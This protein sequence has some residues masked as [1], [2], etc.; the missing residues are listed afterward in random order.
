VIFRTTVQ[1]YPEKVGDQ[2]KIYIARSS[3]LLPPLLEFY[4]KAYA[5]FT[6]FMKDF[7]R[8]QI[9]PRIQNFVPSST[10]DVVDALRKLLKRNREL[11]RYEKT[12]MG[13]FEGILG[14]YLKGN[15]N[16][17]QL[18][19]QRIRGHGPKRKQYRAT[20]SGVSRMRCRELWIRPS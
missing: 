9:Y 19:Q 8:V 15:L 7:V 5:L 16:F 3:P 4:D 10:R 2:L 14:G 12:E 13:D 11:Y 17:G 18:L 6:S 1:V 20:R